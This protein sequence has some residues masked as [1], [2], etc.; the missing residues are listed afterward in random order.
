MSFVNG[1]NKTLKKRKKL[2]DFAAARTSQVIYRFSKNEG[3]VKENSITDSLT[4]VA[5]FGKTH[6]QLKYAFFNHKLKNTN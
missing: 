2:H 1:S 4:R 6:F 3:D 5:K